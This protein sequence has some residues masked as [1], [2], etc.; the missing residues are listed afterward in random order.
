MFADSGGFSA[1]SRGAPVN[2][3]EYVAWVKALPRF[4]TLVST[5]DAIGDAEQTAWNTERMLDAL[6]DEPIMPTFHVG[7][8]WKWLEH[9]VKRGV[10]Q[11][12]LGGMVPYSG[13]VG[14][15]RAWITKCF[16]IIEPGTRVHGF[17][18]TVMP[19][20]K[21]FPFYSVDSSTWTM[22]IRYGNISLFDES[23]G[24]FVILPRYNGG[25]RGKRSEHE[26]LKHRPLLEAY[27]L[28]PATFPESNHDVQGLSIESWRRAELWL[29][30]YKR[31][32][33]SC[34]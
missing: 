5:L 16:E 30:A 34:G 33:A 14:L 24:T 17:G 28:R 32:K 25:A 4:F 21:T 29:Q 19:L 10:R 22:P 2:L 8:E 20:V 13:R 1:W 12:A 31:K 15:L 11:I 6:P 7:S 23:R 26:Y 3:D 18:L 27:G 9:W